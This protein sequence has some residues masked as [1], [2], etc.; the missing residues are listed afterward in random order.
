M[1]AL[2]FNTLYSVKTVVRYKKLET[3]TR[4]PA[5]DLNILNKSFVYIDGFYCPVNLTDLKV[6]L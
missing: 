2:E 1:N 5:Y 4:S 3:K 6:I